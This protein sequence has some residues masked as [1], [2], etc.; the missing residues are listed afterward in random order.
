MKNF[1]LRAGWAIITSRKDG[2]PLFFSR[3]KGPEGVQFPGFS[4]IG[5]AG[6]DE[7]QNAEVKA[8]N[9]F[10]KQ[11][12]DEPEEL[13]NYGKSDEIFIIKRGNKGLVIVNISK[14]TSKIDLEVS[15]KDGKY[16]D[17]AN[18]INFTVKDGKLSGKMP[19]EK[20]AVIY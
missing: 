10:R 1:E 6:N 15:L 7:F 16:T 19:K 4:Q 9:F 20:I 17:K 2:T 5:D 14:K 8:V 12:Q 18:S 11:M 13:L 3:P